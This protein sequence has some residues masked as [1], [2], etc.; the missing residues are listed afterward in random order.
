MDLKE[1]E[2]KLKLDLSNQIINGKIIL[3][4]FRVINE[5]SRKSSAYLDCRYAPFYYH[6]GKHIK[7][8]SFLEIG[9][10]LGLL[11]SSFLISCSSVENFLGYNEKQENLPLRLG[12]SNIRLVFKKDSDFYLGNTFDE[13][14]LDKLNKRK[15]DFILIDKECGYD[16]SSE[17][18]ESAWEVLQDDG[19]MVVEHIN[20]HKVTSR[21]LID[22]LDSKNRTFLNFDTRYGTAMIQK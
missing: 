17:F 21:A 20:H 2:N 5:Q 6:L 12:K 1:L 19:L 9:F 13:E 18:F 4:R 15:W 8:K 3:D 16:K 10:N 14:F 22:F 7:P 11:S